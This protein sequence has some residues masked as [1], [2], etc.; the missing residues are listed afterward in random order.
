MKKKEFLDAWKTLTRVE[1]ETVQMM[2][3]FD[4]DHKIACY[5][6][7]SASCVSKTKSS[8]YQKF[9]LSEELPHLKREIVKR[10]YKRNEKFLGG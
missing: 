6:N 5:R 1:K 3:A 9:G 7:V 10:L 8:I 4:S 2:V